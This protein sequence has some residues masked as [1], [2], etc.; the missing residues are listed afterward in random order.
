M[1]FVL[2][3]FLFICIY[4]NYS[5][6]LSSFSGQFSKKPFYKYGNFL[7]ILVVISSLVVFIP[8][9]SRKL[10]SAR[11]IVKHSLFKLIQFI[12]TPPCCLGLVLFLELIKYQLELDAFDSSEGKYQ[13]VQICTNV[14]SKKGKGTCVLCFIYETKL[15]NKT[16]KYTDGQMETIHRF[17]VHIM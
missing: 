12:V 4:C 11:V 17:T 14:W 8:V 6:C 3:C 16:L 13:F 1:F 7:D 5:W 9:V 2:F 15:E 10:K